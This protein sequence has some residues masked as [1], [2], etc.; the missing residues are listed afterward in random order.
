ML[1]LLSSALVVNDSISINS[2]FAFII[3]YT[4]FNIHV[5]ACFALLV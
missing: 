4:D 3:V 5:F 1:V 2:E